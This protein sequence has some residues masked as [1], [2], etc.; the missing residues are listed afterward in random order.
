MNTNLKK[1]DREMKVDIHKHKR[2]SL[3]KNVQ[4]AIDL[5]NSLEPNQF[6][7]LG[8]ICESILNMRDY[9]LSPHRSH[10]ERD[11]FDNSDLLKNYF[12]NIFDKDI[13]LILSDDPFFCGDSTRE[14]PSPEKIK[15]KSYT[16]SAIFKFLRG[17]AIHSDSDI[18]NEKRLW[19]H[20]F[21]FEKKG[22]AVMFA[23]TRNWVRLPNVLHPNNYDSNNAFIEQLSFDE[24]TMDF[25]L[26]ESIVVNVFRFEVFS[27]ISQ[28]KE[29]YLQSSIGFDADVCNFFKHFGEEEYKSVLRQ[30]KKYKKRFNI[31]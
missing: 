16:R 22:L 12:R 28:K 17:E 8:K 21:A 24:R 30:Y 26:L 27:I 9:L 3:I 6:E 10:K 20:E 29:D 13:V 23:V 18:P 2:E 31:N 5:F 4:D 1:A 19:L 11:I 7:K 25:S 15:H 14:I